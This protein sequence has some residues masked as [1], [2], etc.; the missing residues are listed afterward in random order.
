MGEEKSSIL[1]RLQGPLRRPPGV[2]EED[3]WATTVCIGSNSP[4]ELFQS[5]RS[6]QSLALRAHLMTSSLREVCPQV[7]C[8]PIPKASDLPDPVDREI[9][10]VGAAPG[11]RAIYSRKCVLAAA[12]LSCPLLLCSHARCQGK[13]CFQVLCELRR[14]TRAG[15]KG[16]LGSQTQGCNCDPWPG[17]QREK[18]NRSMA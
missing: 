4:L 16:G 11:W 2:G 7:L 8:S 15:G 6:S 12:L 10:T 9:Q 17:W 13:H 1:G 14:K 5:G 18:H 3:T